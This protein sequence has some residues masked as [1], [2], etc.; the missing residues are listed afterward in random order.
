MWGVGGLGPQRPVLPHACDQAPA[1]P[2]PVGPPSQDLALL[3]GLGGLGGLGVLGEGSTLRGPCNIP[4]QRW[5]RWG[6]GE[7]EG[8][9]NT[10][11]RPVGGQDGA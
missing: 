2:W 3:G 8:E 1:C 6:W 10:E 9:G 11:A 7:Q 4:Q 5:L